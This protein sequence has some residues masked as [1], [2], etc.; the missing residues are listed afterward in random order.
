MSDKR[1]SANGVSLLN[2]SIYSMNK[3]NKYSLFLMRRM[4]SFFLFLRFNPVVGGGS[5][6][7]VIHYSR[8]DQRVSLTKFYSIY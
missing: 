8:N 1:C 6:A 3:L 7:S 4:F 5:N 2:M